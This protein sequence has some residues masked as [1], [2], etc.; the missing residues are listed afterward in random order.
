MK[1][2]LSSFN[3]HFSCAVFFLLIAYCPAVDYRCDWFVTILPL[4][5]LIYSIAKKMGLPA[6]TKLLLVA[7]LY[8]L[9]E[10]WVMHRQVDFVTEI[11]NHMMAFTP[12]LLCVYFDKEYS[13]K[14][15]LAFIQISLILVL[16]T[17]ITTILGLDVYPDASRKLASRGNKLLVDIWYQMNIGG[18]DFIYSL[19]L[20]LPIT[21]WMIQRSDKKF[22]IVNTIIFIIELYCIY[23]SSYTTALVMSLI[24]LC[25]VIVNIQPHLKPFFYFLGSVFFLLSGTGALSDMILWLS[26]QVESSYVADRLLQLSMVLNGTDVNDIGTES[27]ND[28]LVLYKTALDSFLSSPIWGNNISTFNKELLAG[29]SVVLD[30]LAGAGLIGIVFVIVIFKKLFKSTVTRVNNKV[31]SFVVIPWVMFIAI[32]AGNPSAFLLLYMV[33]FTFSSLVQRVEFEENQEYE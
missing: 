13:R 27:T 7:F 12:L 19:V 14:T 21:Y 15:A 25:M 2:I 16:I 24:S 29:H 30:T 31:S 8:S 33:I 11:R 4:L 26:T 1:D 6:L 28:R 20:L 18:F 17:S 23:K 9:F 32:S 5:V 3:L 10:Y 22:K